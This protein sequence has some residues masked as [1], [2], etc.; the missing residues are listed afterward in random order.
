MVPRVLVTGSAGQIGAEL[1][2]YLRSLY[3]NGNVVAGLHKA[4]GGPLL[5]AGPVEVLDIS[6]ASA[7]TEVVKRHGVDTIYHLAA[8]LS[9]VGEN[10]PQ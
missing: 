1:V 10:N 7:L 6:N 4:S 5:R 8:L 3:G 9:A 2:P